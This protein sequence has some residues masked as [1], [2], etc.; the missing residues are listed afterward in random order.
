MT[1]F[2]NANEFNSSPDRCY[3]DALSNNHNHFAPDHTFTVDVARSAPVVARIVLMTK[4][5]G[6]GT[7]E[8]W[9]CVLEE[10]LPKQLSFAT[11]LKCGNA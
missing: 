1:Q 7:A 8:R 10:E 11:W 4:F 2:E 9:F 6:F 3:F 5:D